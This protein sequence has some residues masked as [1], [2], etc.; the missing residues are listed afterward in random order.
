METQRTYRVWVP[1][2]EDRRYPVGPVFD[3]IPAA[4]EWADVEDYGDYLILRTTTTI[5]YDIV[6]RVTV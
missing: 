2:E 5:E 1:N 6:E 3:S 4:A